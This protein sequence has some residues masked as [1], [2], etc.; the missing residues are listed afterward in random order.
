MRD[1]VILSIIFGSL[2]LILFR[3]HIGI[4]LWAWI[5][6][7]SPHRLAWGEAYNYPVAAM[8]GGATLVGLLFYKQPKRIPWNAVTITLAIFIAWMC[9]TTLLALSPMDAEAKWTRT[10]KIL[11][12][13][14]VTLMLMQTRT[15]INWLI[16]VIA[17]SLSFYG[18]KGGL[19]SIVMGGNFK[20]YGP[21]ETFIA[22]NNALALALVM[23]IPF[24]RYLQ[25]VTERVWLKMALGV[26]ILL[27]IFS[28]IASHS[29]GAF[30]AT[31]AMLLFMFAK[32]QRKS[33]ALLVFLVM[34]PVVWSVI[35]ETWYER[36]DTIGTYQ[37][38][39]SAQGRI[40]A[41]W[42]AFNLAKDRPL[43]GG[44]FEA[45]NA[46]LFQRYAPDPDFYQGPHSIYFEV[47]GEQGFVGLVLFI[48]LGVLAYR[49][50]VWVRKN[51]RDRPGMKWAS[52]VSA[53]MCVSLVGYAVGGAFLGLAYFDLYYHIVAILVLTRHYVETQIQEETTA[54]RS[55]TPSN[56]AETILTQ[57]G[58][59]EDR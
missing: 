25:T 23:I 27:N 20:V 24:I 10:M 39:R 53:M 55:T 29:R 47:L 33:A 51:T 18:I 15:R 32:S 17:A 19:G 21:P 59:R 37:E 14:L 38:D 3:P 56:K 12:M 42:F 58:V 34:A 36:I 41:W 16:A 9:L 1:L 28:I 22:D 13:T 11:L 57:S 2:P 5:S 26:V 35:P 31:S 49:S 50:G 44:G 52:D 40:N 48:L 4:L 6:Y 45:F 54:N 7:M 43:V 8:V 30:L 46:A